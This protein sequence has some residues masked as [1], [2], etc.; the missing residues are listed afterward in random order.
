MVGTIE[1]C[2]LLLAAWKFLICNWQTVVVSECFVSV[3]FVQLLARGA[4][5]HQALDE[6]GARGLKR[7]FLATKRHVHVYVDIYSLAWIQST[8]KHYDSRSQFA[9]AIS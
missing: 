4:P 5:H 7:G 6:A 8:L 1:S 2:N 3:D 9:G